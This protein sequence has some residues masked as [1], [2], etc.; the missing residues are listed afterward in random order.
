MNEQQIER[1]GKAARELERLSGYTRL[2]YTDLMARFI[3]A[4]DRLSALA[5]RLDDPAD[6]AV[7]RQAIT[8]L[9]DSFLSAEMLRSLVIEQSKHV[10]ELIEQ[11]AAVKDSYQSGWTDALVDLLTQLAAEDEELRSEVARILHRE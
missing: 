7:M 8:Q 3:G 1:W 2:K 4:L 11:N 5:K 6:A 10:R 9:Q